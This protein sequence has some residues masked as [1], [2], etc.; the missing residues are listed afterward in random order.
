MENSICRGKVERKI[1]EVIVI[2]ST[3][4]MLCCKSLAARHLS[5]SLMKASSGSHTHNAIILS[6]QPT[7]SPTFHA[8]QKTSEAFS[9]FLL[10]LFYSLNKTL[11]TKKMKE[12]KRGTRIYFL[13]IVHSARALKSIL[14]VDV[15]PMR[16][17]VKNCCD[18]SGIRSSEGNYEIKK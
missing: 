4:L 15:E 18:S 13:F 17:R 7:L 3:T 2:I 8:S 10:F 11:K 12:E 9:C 1:V 6:L 16:H 5:Y 14:N